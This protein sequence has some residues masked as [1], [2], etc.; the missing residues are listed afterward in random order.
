[1]TD[2]D[3]NAGSGRPRAAAPG[4]T[5]ARKPYRRPR[6]VSREP[7]EVMAATCTG[8]KAKAG[9]ICTKLKS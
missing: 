3:P 5:P 6:I 7:L 8:A 9:G 1:M 4:G 2:H